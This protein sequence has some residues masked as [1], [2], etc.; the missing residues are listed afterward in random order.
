[1]SPD[2]TPGQIKGLF[3]HLV[4]EVGGIEAAG[5]YLGVSHQ[6]V[7]QLQNIQHVDMP[8]LMQV[9]TLERVVGQ[10]IVTGVLAASAVGAATAHD[11]LTEVFDA[12]EAVVDL[13]RIVRKG[14]DKKTIRAA[15]IRAA[16]ELDDVNA[17]LDRSA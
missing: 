4:K 11:L 3:Y 8:N 12:T 6:R 15:A 10:A 14:G 5:A 9:V 13:Q 16:G 7:S 2:V 1:M 17:A